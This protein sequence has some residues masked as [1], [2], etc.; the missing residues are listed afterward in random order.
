M[1]NTFTLLPPAG[2]GAV[3]TSAP[4]AA[5]GDA[6]CSQS[7]AVCAMSFATKAH[8][9]TMIVENSTNVTVHAFPYTGAPTTLSGYS[10]PAGLLTCTRTSA[11]WRSRNREPRRIGASWKDRAA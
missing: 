10:G 6:T 9:Q 2:N 4:T 5:F 1:P 7:G 11:R 8:Q 3:A